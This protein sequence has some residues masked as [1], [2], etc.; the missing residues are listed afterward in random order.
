MLHFIFAIVQEMIPVA[1][2]AKL[3]TNEVGVRE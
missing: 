1:K 2:L 3:K